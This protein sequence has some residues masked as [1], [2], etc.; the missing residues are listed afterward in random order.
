MH[1]DREN[2]SAKYW[3]DPEVALE[4]NRGFRRAELREIERILHAN[5]EELRNAW[6]E[7]CRRHIHSV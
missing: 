1:V 3:L 7:F 5:V 6:D 4:E 2:Y